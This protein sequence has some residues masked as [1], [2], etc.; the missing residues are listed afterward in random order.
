MSTRVQG[1][2]PDCNPGCEGSI[3]SGCSIKENEMTRVELRKGLSMTR[4][5]DGT[6]WIVTAYGSN[7]GVVTWVQG[8]R[9]E[10][11]LKGWATMRVDEVLPEDTEGLR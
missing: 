7:D 1:H 6:V 11:G 5:S 8:Y 4:V 3:P 10:N 9:T 2:R